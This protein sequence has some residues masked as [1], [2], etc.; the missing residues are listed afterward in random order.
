MAGGKEG[1]FTTADG[2]TGGGR[3]GEVKGGDGE[4]ESV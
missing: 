2:I 4:T 1:V 3:G